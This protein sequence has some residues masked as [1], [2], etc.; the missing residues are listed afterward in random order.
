M[1][2][3][4]LPTMPS[5]YTMVGI[6]PSLLCPVYHPGYTTIPT[7][8][9]SSL[10]A[11]CTLRVVT[12]LGS[13]REKGLGESLSTTLRT[14]RVLRLVGTRRALLLRSSCGNRMKDWITGGSSLCFP[15]G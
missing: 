15:Y 13:R 5:M 1:V 14:S 8:S 2:G 7:L 11:G 12:L 4:D 10:L 3:I 9:S 6:P